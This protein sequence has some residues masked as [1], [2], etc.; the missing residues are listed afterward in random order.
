[1]MC[2]VMKDF[3]GGGVD[4]IRHEL[5]ESSIFRNGEVLIN[6]RF[7]RPATD[8]EIKSARLEGVEEDRPVRRST[9]LKKKS[10]LKAKIAKR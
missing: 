1:M 4:Y 6:Q 5:V 7:L 3:L 9:S 10:G 2:V 8:S